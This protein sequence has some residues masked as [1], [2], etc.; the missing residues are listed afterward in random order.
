MQ[1]SDRRDHG[2][3]IVFP[4]R[5]IRIH[6]EFHFVAVWIAE[7]EAL[8]HGVIAHAVDGDA[9]SFK[10]FLR[11]AQFIQTVSPP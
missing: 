10:I 3:G 1:R 11:R 4:H 5:L 7:I 8:A 2:G 9:G 6:V